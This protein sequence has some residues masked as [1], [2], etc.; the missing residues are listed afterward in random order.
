MHGAWLLSLAMVLSPAPGV[1]LDEAPKAATVK[2]T[3]EKAKEAILLVRSMHSEML[4]A[5]RAIIAKFKALPDSDDIRIDMGKYMYGWSVSDKALVSNQERYE[6]AL[7]TYEKDFSG[8]LLIDE[9]RLYA[10]GIQK[11]AKESLP[12]YERQLLQR[13]QELTEGKYMKD[14]KPVEVTPAL[15]KYIEGMLKILPLEMEYQRALEE[16][17]GKYTVKLANLMH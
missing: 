16:V 7:T 5:Q 2:H 10:K 13:K 15:R 14:G 4:A 1:G 8:D 9:L 17:A 3:G 11:T 12:S 6:G